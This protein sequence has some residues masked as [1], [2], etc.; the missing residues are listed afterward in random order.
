MR[1]HCM[2]Y[3]ANF[4]SSAGLRIGA[5]PEAVMSTPTLKELLNI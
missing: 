3:S 5:L 1:A 2:M 4:F